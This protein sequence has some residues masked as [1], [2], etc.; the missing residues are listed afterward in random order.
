MAA[1]GVRGGASA[2]TRAV[3][4][5]YWM[6]AGAKLESTTRAMLAS[7]DDVAHA[8]DVG[9]RALADGRHFTPWPSGNPLEPYDRQ[10]WEQLQGIC[11]RITGDAFAAHR[12]ARCGPRAGDRGGRGGRVGGK[13]APPPVPA[14]PV[15][16]AQHA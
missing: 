8:L 4:A 14:R 11:R 12:R 5:E 15:G 1:R 10:Q 16:G 2:L 7:Y 9:V 6:Q 13:H 3:L